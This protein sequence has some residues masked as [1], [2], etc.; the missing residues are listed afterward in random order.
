MLITPSNETNLNGEL[1]AN[2]LIICQRTAVSY[3]PSTNV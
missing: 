3:R 1:K 2:N